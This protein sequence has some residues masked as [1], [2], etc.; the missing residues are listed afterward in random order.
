MRVC[1]ACSKADLPHLFVNPIKYS[2]LFE[3]YKNVF[4]DNDKTLVTIHY[5]YI[6]SFFKQIIIKIY[7]TGI[8]FL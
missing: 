6:N 4:V 7:L 8:F 5:V 1:I 3:N 2:T